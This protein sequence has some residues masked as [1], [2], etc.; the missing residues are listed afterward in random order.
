MHNDFYISKLLKKRYPEI[1]TELTLI[2]TAYSLD[3]I[4]EYFKRFKDVKKAPTKKS[5]VV[6]YQSFFIGVIVEIYDP[7][8]IL[9]VKKM[10]YG[11]ASHLA[12]IMQTSRISISEQLTLYRNYKNVYS[13]YKEEAVYIYNSLI[14][15]NEKVN[16]KKRWKI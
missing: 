16:L 3:L 13:D 1:Y 15:G 4:P 2:P 11:L 5:E 12:K 14:Q 8:C 6:I 7:Y 9:G 10:K